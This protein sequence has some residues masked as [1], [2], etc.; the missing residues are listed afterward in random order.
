MNIAHLL[1]RA[2]RVWG[3]RPALSVG[4][5]A[6]LS[7]AEMGCRVPCLAAGLVAAGTL[8][9][10][11]RVAI[12][13]KNCPDYWEVL[14]ALWHAGL[15]AVPIN[16]KLHAREAAWI[17]DNAQ[18]KLAIVSAAFAEDLSV[19]KS[20]MPELQ[21]IIVAEGPE[22]ARLYTAD[23][24]ALA[25]EIRPDHLAWLFY[26]SGT[27]GRPKGAMLTHR[28]LMVAT[29]NY[30]ADVDRVDP[31]DSILHCAPISHGSGMYGLPHLARGANQVIPESGGF[32]PAET[33]D[34]IAHWPG[35]SFFFAPTMVHRLIHAPQIAT[36]DTT[37]LKTIVYGGGPMYVAD[38]RQAMTVLGPKLA[39][40]YGQGEAPMTITGMD[41]QMHVDTGHPRHLNR[42]GSAGVARSD[43]EVCV[44]DA[45]DNPLPVGEIGEVICRGEIVMA[46]YWRNPDAT[47]QALRNGWLH[48]GDMG[49]FDE[50]GFLT[51]KDRSKDMIISGGSNIYPREVEEIL[52]CHEDVSEVSVVGKPHVDWGEEVV[53]FVVP[54]EG[55]A[56]S[57]E[58]LDRLCLDH[59]ARF[60]RPKQYRFVAALPKNNYGKVLKTE[61]RL[62]LEKEG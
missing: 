35:C 47:S 1:H 34:L 52:L 31:T 14:F 60:K 61:L 4:R 26:T 40:I 48:T 46:G 36:A 20:E 51:L 62:L 38:L 42:L 19:L 41:K 54:R 25:T 39:Q 3:E 27:T 56:L 6:R 44:V 11:D 22:F 59:I 23:P 58:V 24:L 2:A 18:A 9:P 50:D 45:D 7:Y 12:L 57:E 5:E 21:R 53:A 13:M 16:A 30:F 55:V 32:D 8:Q 49:S 37:N 43:V 17:I 28:N 33:L 29:M 10:G 15:A